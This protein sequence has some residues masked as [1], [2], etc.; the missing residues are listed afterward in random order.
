MHTCSPHPPAASVAHNL[1]VQLSKSKMIE[2]RTD[3]DEQLSS[4]RWNLSKLIGAVLMVA[5]VLLNGFSA[6]TNVVQ[7]PPR[8]SSEDYNLAQYIVFI[9]EASAVGLQILVCVTYLLVG[10]SMGCHMR[11]K[12]RNVKD[13]IT[14]EPFHGTFRT[15]RRQSWYLKWSSS[16]LERAASF[17]VLKCVV[18]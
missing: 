10:M 18:G 4:V 1:A 12:L 11:K 16:F 7:L 5:R 8:D 17:S 6:T 14:G 15:R 9:F 2:S 13:P 3:L